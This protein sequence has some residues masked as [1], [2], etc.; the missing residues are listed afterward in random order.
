MI[1]LEMEQKFQKLFSSACRGKLLHC[2][3]GDIPRCRN[4]KT[5]PKTVQL[6]VTLIKSKQT[7]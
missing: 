5:H 3:W 1:I 6:I 7:E 4:S 2:P